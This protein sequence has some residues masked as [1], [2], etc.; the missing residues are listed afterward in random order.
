MSRPLYV[1]AGGGGDALAALTVRDAMDDSGTPPVVASYSWDRYLIDP[2]PGPRSPTDFSRL[3]R[4]TEHCWEVTGDSRLK[5][6]GTSGLTVLARHTP[7]R[8]VLL[9][10]RDG[11]VGLRRQISELV[12]YLSADRVTLV[13]VGGDVA[14]RGDEP[15][16][17]SPLGD[18]LALAALVGLPVATDAAIVGP[19]VDGERMCA[20][21]SPGPALQRYS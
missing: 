4:L 20:T 2:A 3:E 11:A 15:T 1:A 18:S 8:F 9:D 16:L 19:G 14:A 21:T 5:A 6:V 12:D 10:P 7:A 13:D 17:L